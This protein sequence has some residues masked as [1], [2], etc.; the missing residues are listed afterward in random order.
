MDSLT[1]AFAEPKRVRYSRYIV[2]A[3][4]MAPKKFLLYYNM[5]RFNQFS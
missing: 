1:P 4:P 2:L 3:V 5:Q